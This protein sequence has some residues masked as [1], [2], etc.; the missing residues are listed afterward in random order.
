MTQ[1]LKIEESSPTER[2]TIIFDVVH[3]PYYSLIHTNYAT[4]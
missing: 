4:N 2:I 3:L 1:E